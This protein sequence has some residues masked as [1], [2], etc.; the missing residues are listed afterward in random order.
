[1]HVGDSQKLKHCVAKKKHDVQN[2]NMPFTWMCYKNVSFHK[3]MELN[4]KKMCNLLS[5]ETVMHLNSVIKY[6]MP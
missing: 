4:K 3:L 1:M 6:E 2:V 5:K